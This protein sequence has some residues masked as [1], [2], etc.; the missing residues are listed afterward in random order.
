MTRLCAMAELP[1]EIV[2]RGAHVLGPVRIRVSLF[3]PGTER[4]QLLRCW[5]ERDAVGEVE[6]AIAQ[7]EELRSEEI[8]AAETTELDR[9]AGE[10]DDE[11]L[12]PVGWQIAHEGARAVV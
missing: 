2:E 6:A 9:L 4:L 3:D 10:H 7:R 11:S 5:C 12:V 1:R 8:F